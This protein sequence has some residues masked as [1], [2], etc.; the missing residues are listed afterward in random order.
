MLLYGC[1]HPISPEGGPKDVNPPRVISCDPPNSATEFKGGSFRIDFNEF[2]NLKNPVNEIFI[3]PPLKSPID[4]RVRGK[5]LIVRLD[6]SLAAN[7]TYSVTFGNAI[8]DLT[9]GNVLKGFNYVF[10]T[11]HYV[12]S[13][14]LQGTLQ[15]AFDH[16]LQKDVFIE[17][18]IS[19]NDTLPLDSLPLHVAP[20]YVTKTDE[21]GNFMFHNLKQGEFLLFALADQNGDLIFNQ[22]SEK[23]A[24]NDSLVK[25]YYIRVPKPDTLANDS[26][27]PDH[28]NVVP[29]RKKSADSLK[30]ADSMN[31]INS[32]RQNLLNYPSASL[33]LF[34]STDSVQRIKHASF[35]MEGK[36][37]VVFRFP[38]KNLRVV[39]LNFDSISPWY[40]EELSKQGDSVTLWITRP[41]V[42]SLVAKVI[43]GNKTIDTVRLEVTK[44]EIRKKSSGKEKQVQL[45]IS[46]AA[47]HSGLNQ[48]KNK[49]T[50][51]FSYP[52]IRWNFSKV[53]L[54]SAK[55]TIHPDISFSDS[56]KREIIIQHKWDEEK[57]YK[58]II[59]DSVF[60]GIQNF[61]HDSVFLEFKTRAE[62]DFG[63]L[64][65]SM[66]M[67]KRPGQYIV[68][69]MNE[70][71]SAV[72]E[73]KII[74]GSE[75]IHF[76]FMPPGK[77]KLKAI[78]DRNRNGHWDTGNYKLKIQPE[79]VIYLPKTVT[80]RAN[81][82]VEEAWN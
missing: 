75:K 53:L 71:E 1:A 43:L 9:E 41:N 64:I 69:L 15:T 2:I 6:D 19:N 63:N 60:F 82:D 17:L 3:S 36:A 25:P 57:T 79:E 27:H 24:F 49:L 30:V 73:E 58:I 74:T 31:K 37:L 70:N 42:D 20:Y 65:V 23:I 26:V 32:T 14:S 80:I 46:N 47:S 39:P 34:E 45:G 72:F 29:V 44:K 5:S 8:L 54:V 21:Q 51:N 50:L 18:Y 13:L 4:T 61:T 22:P 55:D 59:P 10:S 76:D 78:Y 66:N 40:I 62:K 33:F 11:G 48:Y 77:Y 12:D 68:Q 7:T 56:L 38:V 52:L 35:P 81:W 28:H 16:K 67:E